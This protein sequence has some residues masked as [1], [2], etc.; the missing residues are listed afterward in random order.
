MLP[1]TGPFEVTNYFPD[2]AV[3][4]ERNPN[5]F[6]YELD[7]GPHN[8]TRIILKW[9]PNVA[10]RWWAL[11]AH[12]I[13]FCDPPVIKPPI[14]ETYPDLR[15]WQYDCPASNPVFFNLDN[16]HLSNRYV[17]QAIA[18]AIPYEHIF[19]NILPDWDVETAYQGKTLITPL[20][21]YTD[22]SNVTVHLFNDELELYEYDI[23]KAQKYMDMWAYSQPAHAPEGSPEV[24]LG[25]VGDADFSGKVNFD[26]W[27][28]WWANFGKS[29]SEWPWTPGCDVDPDFD[30]TDAVNLADYDEWVQSWGK[31]YPFEDAR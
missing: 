30:N 25:P 20:H 14:W 9:M 8:V 27:F 26:D 7:W 3:L 24:A 23:A 5:Y 4:L 19:N 11:R 21:Y 28:I 17:R 1:G 6:G 29:S 2:D 10:D 15:E 16:R 18:H 31:A 13:D 22:E 12:E